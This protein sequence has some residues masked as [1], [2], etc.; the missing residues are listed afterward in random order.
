M[1]I[2]GLLFL[3]C[4]GCSKEGNNSKVDS[5]ADSAQN[6]VE[7]HFQYLN[8][9]DKDKLLTTLTEHWNAPNVVYGFENLDSIKILN[10]EEEKSKEIRK[11][12]LR[13]G[14]GS[15]TGTTA[16]NLKVY[17]VYY[18]VRYKND[19]IGPQ[20]SGTHEWWYFVIKKDESSPWLIDDFGV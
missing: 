19:G 4:V 8:E 6:V 16:N 3:I 13:N 18:N 9:K 10:I 14:R 2:L 1:I 20:D 5:Q 11:G 15:I 12:Y 17:K 7:K